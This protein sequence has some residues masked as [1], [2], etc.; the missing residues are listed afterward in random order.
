MCW[1]NAHYLNPISMPVWQTIFLREFIRE[2]YLCSKSHN[3]LSTCQAYRWKICGII[4]HMKNRVSFGFF[5]CFIWDFR[6]WKLIF[7]L[8]SQFWESCFKMVLSCYFTNRIWSSSPGIDHLGRNETFLHRML[9]SK[10]QM[11]D[12][13]PGCKIPRLGCN[14]S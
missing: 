13:C 8:M 2:W 3:I 14:T 12:M 4:D 9:W 1:E 10:W 7:Y 11:L 6:F 5:R